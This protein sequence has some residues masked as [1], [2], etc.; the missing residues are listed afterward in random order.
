MFLGSTL[1]AIALSLQMAAAGYAI[2]LFFRA[3]AYRLA[4]GLLA[5]G[6]G[7][8][9]GR[10]ISL[11]LHALNNGSVNLV[12]AYF[13][14]TISLLL[15]LGM[16][17]FKRL[18][19]ELEDQ[20]FLLKEYSKIDSLTSAMSRPETFARAS[21]EIERSFRNNQC[22]AFLM[23]DIDRFKNV[24]DT[25]G[26]P[27]GDITLINLVK[28]CQ[29]ELRSIDIFGRVGGEEFLVVLPETN[30][31][32]AYEV[33]ERLRKKVAEKACA[34]WEGNEILITIS[35]GIS[36]FN[37]SVDKARITK[38]ILQK[39]YK[40]CDSAMYQAKKLGRNKVHY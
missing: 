24:N 10:P 40:A 37:P 30:T 39:Y 34:I 19:I 22:L 29:D 4:C 20:Q 1:Y 6:L 2:N 17:Q 3:R 25:Y 15:L 13:S 7:L 27:A 32:H 33:A 14:I 11:L 12:D 23:I 18:L 26:H 28:C 36:V 35:I 5:L 31:H 8:M 16:F 21:I 9:M 38:V